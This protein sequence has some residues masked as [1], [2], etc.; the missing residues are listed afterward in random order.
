VTINV[1]KPIDKK[2]KLTGVIDKVEGDIIM[3]LLLNN[4]I[5]EIPFQAMSKARLVPDYSIK[6]G[7]RNGK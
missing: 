1:F 7:G 3:L 2:R 5:I 6:K 4:Q